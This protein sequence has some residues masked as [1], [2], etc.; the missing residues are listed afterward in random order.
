MDY[1]AIL[2]GNLGEHFFRFCE[3][4]LISWDFSNTKKDKIT[5]LKNSARCAKALQKWEYL[6]KYFQII[7]QGF[8]HF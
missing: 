1:T 3:I 4:L 7:E 5:R 6:H 8:Y 2:L